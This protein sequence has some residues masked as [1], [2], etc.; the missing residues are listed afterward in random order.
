MLDRL[1]LTLRTQGVSG[2]ELAQ[3]NVLQLD[4]LPDSWNG[5][6]LVVSASMLEY[7]VRERFS[8]AV[9]GLRGLMAPGGRFVLFCTR[10]NWLT[11][12]LIGRWWEGNL[13]SEHELRGALEAAGFDEIVFGYFPPAFRYLGLWGHVVECS[14]SPRPRLSATC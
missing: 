2:V 3:A 14:N 11:G 7:V 9:A 6:D 4:Q 13:Y 1:A 8:D 5:Y 12:P 10:R